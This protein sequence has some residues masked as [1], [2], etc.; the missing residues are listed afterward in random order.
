MSNITVATH[1]KLLAKK[2][3]ASRKKLQGL[4]GMS[5]K[6]KEVWEMTF[7]EFYNS[8]N[9]KWWLYELSDSFNNDTLAEKILAQALSKNED[10]V[11]G[12]YLYDETQKEYEKLVSGNK[13]SREKKRSERRKNIS[14]G[15]YKNIIQKAISENKQIPAEVLA[16]YP[17]LLKNQATNFLQQYK[18]DS[19]GLQGIKKE[20]T[21]SFTAYITAANPRQDKQKEA[22]R[23]FCSWH[24][25]TALGLC[26][27]AT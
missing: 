3:V 2:T 11:F 8:I 5:K 16:E 22:G 25:S 17:D 18:N 12:E 10:I 19:Q 15:I 24:K 7:E 20:T 13:I 14:R 26:K 1:K 23:N 4:K 9:K 21:I 6:E 27:Q